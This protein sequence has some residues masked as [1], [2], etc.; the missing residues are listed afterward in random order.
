MSGRQA[1][2]E[3]F[4][5]QSPYE[6]TGL[7]QSLPSTLAITTNYDRGK[8]GE[9]S[10]FSRFERGSVDRDLNLNSERAADTDRPSYSR[11]ER[12]SVDR[13]TKSSLVD[14]VSDRPKLSDRS[15]YSR[16]DRGSVDRDTRSSYTDSSS[17]RLHTYRTPHSKYDRNFSIDRTIQYSPRSTTPSTVLSDK[18]PRSGLST[19]KPTYFSTLDSN[20]SRYAYKPSSYYTS[21]G[22]SSALASQIN[23][24]LLT[25]F[26][27]PTARRHRRNKSHA[28]F[29]DP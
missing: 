3:P 26:Y 29:T 7:D 21:S 10:A 15:T 13:D 4:S 25:R 23:P 20:V 12:G 6:L 19:I 22:T 5:Y 27:E 18:P 28:F 8:T 14:V 2:I 11:Y 16:Y 17:D 24:D 1:S 9:R